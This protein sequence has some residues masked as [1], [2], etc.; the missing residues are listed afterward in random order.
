[1]RTTIT[2]DNTG[3]DLDLLFTNNSVFVSTET[4]GL[5][6]GEGAKNSVGEKYG[7]SWK[8]T[9]STR[10]F[11][12]WRDIKKEGAKSYDILYEKQK[13]LKLPFSFPFYGGLYDTIWISRNGYVAVVQ[14]T[15]DVFTGEFRKDDGIRGMI[16]PFYSNLVPDGPDN[17]IWVLSD[18]DRVFVF[19]DGF[20]G[21]EVNTSGGNIYFQ[22]ELVKDGSIFF[23]Y[24][25]VNYFTHG[26][27]YGLESPD[28]SETFETYRSWV[29]HWGIVDDSTTIA[30]FPPL[31]DR[32]A[33]GMTQSFN[34]LLDGR[35]VFRPGTYH[36][37][38]VLQTNSMDAPEKLIPVTLNVTGTAVIP[39]PD[40]I[41]WDEVIFTPDKKIRQRFYLTNTGH[42]IAEVS[43]IRGTGMYEFRFYDEKGNE[44]KK[45][46]TGTL[47]RPIV[48][49][50][51]DR[52]PVEL[53]VVVHE[54]TPVEGSLTFSGNFSSVTTPVIARVVE[55]PLFSWDA[56][57]QQYTPVNTLK[58]AYSFT[59]RNDGTTPLRYHLVPAVVPTG[60]GGENPPPEVDELGYYTFEQPVT[61]DSLARESKEK[62]DGYERPLIPVLLAFANEFTAPAGGF[63]LTHIKVNG[64]FK[65]LEEYISIRV[66]KGGDEPM[67]GE[68]VYKQEFPTYRYVLQ[69][70]VYFPLAFPLR[71]EEG[72]KFYI[73]VMPPMASEYLGYDIAP[74]EQ[75]AATSWAANY[76]SWSQD[77]PWN[78]QQY[79]SMLRLYKIRAL[80][81]AGEGLWLELDNMNG[82]LRQGETV[83]VTATADPVLAGKGHH[84]AIVRASTNDIDHPVNEFSIEMDVNGPPDL[85]YRP[86]MYTDTVKTRETDTLVLN[87]VFEDPEGEAMDISLDPH[88]ETL[89]PVL[90]RTGPQTAQ[91]IFRTDYNSAGTYQYTVTLTDS[92]GNKVSD[93]ILLKVED[94][95]RPPV[96]NPD[97]SLIRL[98]MAGPE[99][100]LM[101][102]DPV[103]LFSDPD[104]DELTVLAGNYTPDMLDMALGYR[105]IDLHPLQPGTGFVVFGADD[106]KE[107]GFVVYGIYVQIIDD[108]SQTGTVA[109]GYPAG[110]AELITQGETFS[111]YPNPVTTLSANFIYKLE[112]AGEVSFEVYDMR[113][114]RQLT[115][116][117]GEQEEGIYTHKIDV[118]GL[119]AGIYICKLVVNGHV[120]GSTNLIVK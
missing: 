96:L 108:A 67:Q 72:E 99:G 92:A 6:N 58:P 86:N 98:N 68:L 78:W 100:G 84:K 29:L 52:I 93:N 79:N 47:F 32:L 22:L 110:A 119:A 20:R 94:K 30:I 85:L 61:V 39:A 2:T 70:W 64:I 113:G 12:Q 76:R 103:S 33:G 45:T 60:E 111:V 74:N 101:T 69:Q 91:L 89:R 11:Y 37:T 28:E 8:V 1:M 9:D 48:V 36:D 65:S 27:N 23:H 15:A 105:Y 41:V 24:R 18:T 26:L 34:L 63:Y 62:A 71:F 104:G 14:P 17:H 120:I 51:W 44:I 66:Y 97:Y 75:A 107:D 25:S 21:E 87:Y 10:V 4:P 7:Y 40:S 56:T 57:D 117:A 35:K 59:M 81:A 46:S 31:R 5:L 109:D 102:I 13:A 116:Q 112:E 88:G 106:G 3:S 90:V 118:A 42:D 53:E 73:V 55:S 82:T 50:P 49:K 83:T 19:W 16:A 114:I 77:R 95:N 38:L 43:S 115:L 80:T 54:Q